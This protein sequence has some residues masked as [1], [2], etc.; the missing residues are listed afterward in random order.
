MNTKHVKMAP[1]SRPEK[2]QY[3]NIFFGF[4]KLF[5]VFRNHLNLVIFQV[6]FRYDFILG[7]VK[8]LMCAEV[9]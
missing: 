7:C 5:R 8:I 1:Q 9:R 6:N 3:L 4:R 2:L